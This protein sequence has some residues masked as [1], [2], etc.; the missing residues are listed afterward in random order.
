[1]VTATPNGTYAAA[2]TYVPIFTN[3]LV[4][5][6]ASV[7]F[8]SIP[9][10][11]TDLVLVINC[12]GSTTAVD[13]LLRVGN[14]S[15]DTGSNYTATYLYGNGTAAGSYR[16]TSNTYLYLASYA[17]TTTTFESVFITHLMNYA[18]TTTNKSVLVRANTTSRDAEVGAGLWRS[19]SAI[20]TIS[21]IRGSGNFVTGSTFSLY[22]IKAA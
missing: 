13:A 18:N 16:F 6:Q 7:I 15:V 19:T 21:V 22:G 20:D 10:T 17:A 14:G 4:S 5:A 8:S 11:Y 3:T 12:A 1:M 9:S 2:N